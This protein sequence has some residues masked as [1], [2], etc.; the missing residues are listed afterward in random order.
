M[1][2]D[3]VPATNG[4]RSTMERPDAI[5]IGSGLGGLAAA[6]ALAKSGKRP[7]VLEHHFLPGGNT[8]TFRRR[9]MFDFDVGLHVIGGCEAG[10]A[11]PSMLEQLGVEGVEFVPM[12]PDGFE[13]VMTPDLT[14]GVPAGWDRYEER[15]REAFPGE[16]AAISRY[17]EYVR[18]VVAAVGGAG[19]EPP[20]VQ[21][22]LDK[23]WGE[24]TLGDLFDTLEFSVR[25]RHVLAAQSGAYGAPP[26]RASLGEH[27]MVLD[28]YLHSGGY[29]VRRG[30]RAIIDGLLRVIQGGGG[31][32]RLRSRVERILIEDG[33]AAGVR[34]AKGE[35]FRAPLVI[36][37]ADAKR[38]LLE[39]VGEERLSPAL[40]QRMKE[41]R[42]AL[43]MF[44]I[45]MAMR[46]PP[47]ELG[48]PN[49]TI[50]LIPGYTQEE[51]YE[52]CYAGR[53]PDKPFVIISIAS[54]KDSE[55]E[56]IAPQGYTNLQLMTVAPAQLTSWGAERSPAEGGRYRH[57]AS[58][59][60]TK[61]LLRER[62]HASVEEL[63]P[64]FIRNV[65][66]E[67]CATPLTQ[68]RFTR[69]TGGTGYGFEHTPDQ[70]LSKRLSFQTEV[71]GLYLCGQNTI[72][73]HGILPAVVSGV[74]AAQAALAAG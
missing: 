69:S 74:S 21:R 33:R 29:Y 43:P 41:F 59:E 70:F 23:P 24:L 13:T 36:S 10:G 61:A 71:P 18:F 22:L 7:L 60:V 28:H 66:W 31:E 1:A 5:V 6:A 47:E 11:F 58:Y 63:M 35:E 64:G 27:A 32:V 20:A 55:S 38:T 26:S 12:D 45:Y 68:E 4:A 48:L 65:V 16:R 50:C 39:M 73:G 2:L 3:T 72:I 9:K 54:L 56:N 17:I 25:L 53:V 46:V 67:E 40:A 37:N 15:L 49:S 62:I 14:F 44:I 51:D 42:M 57:T 30:S 52:A 34:L 8:Q 19:G